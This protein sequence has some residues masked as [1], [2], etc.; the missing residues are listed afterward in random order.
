MAETG[1]GRSGPRGHGRLRRAG[2]L[3]AL[4]ALALTLGVIAAPSPAGAAPCDAPV[5]SPIACENSK[6]GNPASE[7]DISGSDTTI[8]GFATDMSVNKGT[9][10]SFK[11]KASTTNYRIDIYRVGYYGGNGARKVASVNPT[12]AQ[13]QPN[14]LTQSTTGLVDCGNWA[15]TAAWAVPADAVSGVYIARLVRNDTG[16]ASHILFVVRDDASHSS[17]L[18][19]TSDTTWQAYNQYGGNSLYVGNPAGRAYKV[20]YNRPVTT[21]DTGAED[22][23]F[24]AEYPMV[25]FLEANGFDVSYTSGVD[26]DRNGSLIQQHRTFLSVGHDEYWSGG[27]RTNVEAARAAGVNLAF[28]SGNEVFWKTRW[29]SSIATGGATYRTLVSYKE[30]HANA[31]I[32]PLDPPTWTGTWRDP[33]FSPPADGGRPENA[34]TGTIFTVNDGANGT[35]SIVVPSDD[36]KMRFW[37]NTTV[38]SLSSGQSATLPNGTLGYEW[39]E[40][41]DNGSRPAGQIRLSTA[42]Y[43]VGSKLQDYGSTYGAD[44]ATHHLTLYRGSGGGL[45]FGAG[46]A[47]W[48]WGLDANHDRGSTAADTRMKQATLNLLAD[49]GAQPATIQAGLTAATASTDTTAPTSTITSPAAGATVPTGQPLTI[50]GTAA[51]TGGGVVGGVEVSVDNGATWHPATGRGTWSFTY[52]PSVDGTVTVRSRAADDSANLESPKPGNTITVGTGGSACPCTTMWPASATPTNPSEPDGSAVELGV[53]FQ[54]DQAGTITGIRFY[55]GSGNTGTHVGNLWS[56]TG[57]RLATANFSGETASGW[58]QV[59]FTTP[60]SI[61]ANTTYVASYFAPA[62]V[63]AADSNYFATAGVDRPPL[64]ALSNGSSGGNGVYAYGGSPSFPNQTYQSTNYWVDVVYAPSGGDTTPPT[65]TA[66]TPASG[67]TG[68]NVASNATATFSEAVQSATISFT[69]RDAASNAVAAAV[70]YDATTRTATLN[71]NA[72]LAAGA[73]YTATVT[74]A[75]DTAGNTMAGSTTW[76][77]TTAAA[78]DTTPPTVTATSPASGATGVSVA[79][80]VTATF[81]E[82]VQSATVSFTLR[83]AASNAVAAAVTYDDPTR[84]ATLNPTADLAAGAT[85][86]ATVT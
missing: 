58:Q 63:Y 31:V 43:S 32:D 46:S 70:T 52:T 42:T 76:S 62:G 34:L 56:S 24:N 40:D 50:S 35:T 12:A 78:V 22:S 80:N 21:R 16:G 5:T 47:Q 23:F 33:R 15:V 71:P 53:K 9:T 27:Q 84:T 69:L 86:T 7:W 85:Y 75:K 26:S 59:N 38:A 49:M 3:V 65:V 39:D 28:F 67:A 83:D 73:T 60:V 64:H 25:R 1:R 48:A 4:G 66:T 13:S 51:D 61:T 2:A 8:L 74:G 44:T 54:S 18:F 10:V 6:P 11:V 45:V 55:K 77:F 17:L 29:E 14:C 81:S 20:S 19:Q 82:S 79:S 41:L 72:D 57:T 30:T 68:V 36:G 37:R